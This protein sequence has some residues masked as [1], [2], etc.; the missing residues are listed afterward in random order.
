MA[1]RKDR[2]YPVPEVGADGE[3]LVKQQE[4]ERRYFSAAMLDKYER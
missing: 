3:G 2:P 4:L 1:Q